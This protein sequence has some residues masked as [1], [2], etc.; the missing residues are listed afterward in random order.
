M[1]AS[2]TKAVFLLGLD[3]EELLALGT[4]ALV[5]VTGLLFCAALRQI[6]QI[7]HENKKAATLAACSQ[8]DQNPSL[9]E[10][11]RRLWVARENGK[12][13]KNPKQ[14]RPYIIVLLNHLDAIAIGIEQGLYIESLA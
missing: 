2:T 3:A 12:L 1:Q 11:L 8:Y 7:R 13:E 10:A 9:N 5:L 4:W 6:R 14:F